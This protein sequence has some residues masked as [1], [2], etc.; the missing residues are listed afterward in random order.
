VWAGRG[1]G[2]NCSVCGTPI[3]GTE[4]EY[5]IRASGADLFAHVPCFDLWAEE[6]SALGWARTDGEPG[7]PSWAAW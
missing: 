4:I 1:I 2:H 3:P 6:A 5:E 7:G